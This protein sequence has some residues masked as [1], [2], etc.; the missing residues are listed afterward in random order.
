MLMLLKLYKRHAT[1]TN[2]KR[3]RR[4]NFC[5]INERSFD[6]F[7]CLREYIQLL[8][9]DER[10][11]RFE[12]FERFERFEHFERFEQFERFERLVSTSL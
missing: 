3:W 1:K 4:F 6:V 11:E 8:E 7:V 10:I 9:R 12:H 5:A 2:K